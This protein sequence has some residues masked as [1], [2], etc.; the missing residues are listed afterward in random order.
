MRGLSKPVYG[1]RYLCKKLLSS[2]L[3]HP[4]H[5]FISFTGILERMI[6]LFLSLSLTL[7]FALPCFAKKKAPDYDKPNIDFENP[8]T[9]IDPIEGLRN[10]HYV[11]RAILSS[12]ARHTSRFD[13]DRPYINHLM[14]FSAVLQRDLFTKYVAGLQALSAGYITENGHGFEA[15]LEFASVSN[16]FIGYRKIFRPES[17]SVWPFAGFG[18]GTEVTF[19]RFADG[20]TQAPVYNGLKQMGFGNVGFLVPLADI[21]IKA[22]ARFNFYGTDRLILATGIGVIFFL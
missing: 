17:F 19:F 20:P 15:G 12:M 11:R 6:R 10:K 18:A 8:D 4:D 5:Q 2:L 14:G 9:L 3:T 21:G 16:L 22:E 7:F 13:F 1:T